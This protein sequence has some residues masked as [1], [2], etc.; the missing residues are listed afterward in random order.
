MHETATP[1]EIGFPSTHWSSVLAAGDIESQE[2]SEALGALL[3]RYQ[4]ALTWYLRQKFWVDGDAGSDILQSFIAEVVLAKELIRKA[5]P[6]KGHQFRKFLLTAFHNF[7]ASHVRRTK[8]QKRSP[9]GGFVSLDESPDREMGYV[10]EPSPEVFDVAWARG[11]IG[12]ALRL[13]KAECEASGRPDIWGMFEGRLVGPIL[14]G[15]EPVAYDELVKRFA[16]QSPVQAQNLLVTAKR[17]F[18]RCLSAAVA[19][20]ATSEQDIESELRE[21]QIVLAHATS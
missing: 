17:M 4:P 8:A 13:M 21:L 18:S 11:V 6:E 2:G 3:H 14:E 5:R 10:P 20:Y 1:K 7:A 15:S 19:E 16:L 12:E 9:S